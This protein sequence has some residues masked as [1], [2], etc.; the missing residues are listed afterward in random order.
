[1]AQQSHMMTVQNTVA[2][3]AARNNGE[4]AGDAVSAAMNTMTRQ[5][6]K[7]VLNTLSELCRRGRLQRLRQGVYAPVADTKPPE[8]RQ[9]MWSL[10]RMRRSGVTVDDLVE[11]AG[12][13]RDYAAE[14][15]RM[16]TRR[17]V[18]RMVD[19]PGMPALWI[20]VKDSVEMPIDNE[21][22]SRLRKLRQQRK[23]QIAVRLD[24]IDAAMGEIRTIINDMDKDA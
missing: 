7:N 21:K 16:L 17:E 15:L 1:M 5:Q 13:S 11:L 12:V 14:W 18:V 20:L 8:K 19:R 4:A 22:A 2:E 9:V 6:H 24:V 23:Q 3:I 10:L